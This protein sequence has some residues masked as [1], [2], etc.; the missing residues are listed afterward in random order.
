M[1]KEK[2]V[3]LYEPSQMEVKRILALQEEFKKYGLNVSWLTEPEDVI[4]IVK[5]DPDKIAK[6][7]TK[8]GKKGKDGIFGGQ[9][10][11]MKVREI[12]LKECRDIPVDLTT[13]SYKVYDALNSGV[14]L[15]W[16]YFRNKVIIENYL[17]NIGKIV[18]SKG[19]VIDDFNHLIKSGRYKP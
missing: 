6:V 14:P 7:I 15:N 4:Y 18:S 2:C 19:A 1:K 9:N 5:K 8:F 17:A 10:I 13:R 3:L 11:A 12:S 16:E